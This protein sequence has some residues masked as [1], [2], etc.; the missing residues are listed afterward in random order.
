MFLA[1]LVSVAATLF[2]P[3]TSADALDTDERSDGSLIVE[4]PATAGTVQLW[5]DVE[6]PGLAAA[7]VFLQRAGENVALRSTPFGAGAVLTHD[8]SATQ[9]RLGVRR[10]VLVDIAV[11][12]VDVNGRVLASDAARVSLRAVQEGDAPPTTPPGTTTPPV[13]TPPDTTTPPATTP[14]GTTPPTTLP[15]TSQA[16]GQ[17]NPPTQTS[18]PRHPAPSSPTRPGLPN[19]GADGNAS[20]AAAALCSVSLR[21]EVRS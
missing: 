15:P 13:T 14:P 6:A 1:L 2:L 3:A 8:G 5:M 17:G 7:D 10:N 9:L 21:P 18:T 20:G 16:P 4:I 12:L 19:T 11:T